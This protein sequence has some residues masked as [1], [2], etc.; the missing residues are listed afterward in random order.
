MGDA[1][2]KRFFMLH[3]L[4]PFVLR[5]LVVLHIIYL[6]ETGSSNPLGVG[7]ECDKVPFHRYFVVKDLLGAVVLMLIL[8]RICFFSPDLFLDPV[9]FVPADPIKTP[10][11]IQPE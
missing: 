11:H 7:A 9:N 8:L 1:T 2:L 6:H 4:L 5:G 3:F 10:L